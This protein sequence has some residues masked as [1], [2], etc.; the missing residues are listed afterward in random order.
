[1][2][3]SKS[4]RALLLKYPLPMLLKGIL[5][6]WET[7]Q[8]IPRRL[9]THHSYYMPPCMVIPLYIGN[10]QLFPT[11]VLITVHSSPELYTDYWEIGLLSTSL[12]VGVSQLSKSSV[13]CPHSR[14][15]N[16]P[17]C[18][19]IKYSHLKWVQLY[20]TELIILGNLLRSPISIALKIKIIQTQWE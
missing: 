6:A 14:D 20:F 4:V 5:W 8:L 19:S 3:F 2:I 7:D 16:Y 1:M 12:C 10:N 13:K 15:K 11:I 9:L 18:T 17:G